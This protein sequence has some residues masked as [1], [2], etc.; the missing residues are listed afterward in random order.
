MA[1]LGLRAA[2]EPEAYPVRAAKQAVPVRRRQAVVVTDGEGRV[3]LVATHSTGLVRAAATRVL[4]LE[5]GRLLADVADVPR[6]A[7]LPELFARWS[8]TAAKE[9][10]P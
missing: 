6:D 8:G 1:L 10:A 9:A 4:Y 2:G 7:G 3:L 5:R